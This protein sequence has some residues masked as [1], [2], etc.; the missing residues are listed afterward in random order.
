LGLRD[1][2]RLPL[3][4]GA[5]GPG[6]RMGRGSGAASASPS[7]LDAASSGRVD[8]RAAVL[9]EGTILWPEDYPHHH[10]WQQSA[11]I[12]SEVRAPSAIGRRRLNLPSIDASSIHQPASQPDIHA[13]LGVSICLLLLLLLLPATCCFAAAVLIAVHQRTRWMDD[14]LRVTRLDGQPP[15][16]CFC[17]HVL[18]L[19]ASS[20]GSE[21]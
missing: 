12:W 6:V 7:S 9:Y 16:R 15:V 14:G 1:P 13:S 18:L 8:R 20:V 21:L 19:T 17:L 10:R 11:C 5:L 2:G 3:A 4:A